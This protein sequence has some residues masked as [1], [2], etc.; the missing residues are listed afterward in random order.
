MNKK[1]KKLQSEIGSF[2]RQYERKSYP[3]RD[4]N[5]RQYDR[6]V[7]S[8]IK[9]LDATELSEFINGDGSGIPPDLDELWSNFNLIPGVKFVLNASVEILKGKYIG[10]KGIIVSLQALNPEPRYLIELSSGEYVNVH[11][12]QLIDQYNPPDPR[13]A[14]L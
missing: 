13:F 6:K 12:S 2:L 9:K 8:Q 4:P 3:N 1:R 7:E 14:G 10:E 11:E 5:D